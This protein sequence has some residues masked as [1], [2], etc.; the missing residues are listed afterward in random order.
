VPLCTSIELM[1][2]VIEYELFAL[3]DHVS[4]IPGRAGELPVM[5]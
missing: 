2:H 1:L 4:S 5:F 3:Q